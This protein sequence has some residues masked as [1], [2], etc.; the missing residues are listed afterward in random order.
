MKALLFLLMIF[1]IVG[2]GAEGSRRNY[3]ITEG[4]KTEVVEEDDS[5]VHK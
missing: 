3:I 4:E 1:F 2:C 5:P